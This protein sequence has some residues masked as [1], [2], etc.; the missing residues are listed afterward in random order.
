MKLVRLGG[1]IRACRKEIEMRVIPHAV[2][3][4]VAV[5]LLAGSVAR[6]AEKKITRAELPPAV[7]K[8]VAELA[9]GATIRG[10][11]KEIEQGKTTYE[12][13]LTVNGHG[14]DV[15]IDDG[16]KVVEVEE[17]L[18]LDTLP[19]AVKEGLKK[20]AGAGQIVKVE[21]LTKSG[22]LVAYEA[23]VKTGSKRAEV[24]V[25]PDGKALAQRE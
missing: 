1:L 16:G 5:L 6:G 21:S 24:Q 15:S 14:R 4:S 7:E 22:K 19:P 3:A 20:A 2:G 9:K 11:S 18:A 17:E 12:V 13:E 23:A 10:F 8:T 25:D